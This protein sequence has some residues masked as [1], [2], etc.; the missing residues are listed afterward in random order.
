M[1]ELN[2]SFALVAL[3]TRISSSVDVYKMHTRSRQICLHETYVQVWWQGA[4]PIVNTMTGDVTTH[5]SAPSAY[6]A[7]RHAAAA[8]S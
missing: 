3:S 7:A 1:N 2:R 8:L 4:A 6:R 5:S